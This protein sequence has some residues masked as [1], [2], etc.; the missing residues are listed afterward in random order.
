MIFM[1]LKRNEYV[2]CIFFH[3]VHVYKEYVILYFSV[4]FLEK[5]EAM[6]FCP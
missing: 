5:E 2:L 4:F 3:D 1:I 6:L